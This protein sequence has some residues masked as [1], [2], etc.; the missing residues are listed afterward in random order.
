MVYAFLQFYND[1]MSIQKFL[2]SQKSITSGWLHISIG[3]GLFAGFL[4]IAQAWFL[5]KTVNSVVFENLELSD[6][7]GWL[8]LLLGVFIIRAFLAW[9]SEQAAFHA[10]AKIKQQ[11]RR[12]LKLGT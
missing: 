2:K 4:L 3:L 1:S 5:A 12:E 7:Q 8:W 9:A 11:L 6:V 10:S